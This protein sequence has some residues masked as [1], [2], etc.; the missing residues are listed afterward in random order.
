MDLEE[1]DDYFSTL[2]PENTLENINNLIYK[3]HDFSK[4]SKNE[5]ITEPL[6]NDSTDSENEEDTL[7]ISD[8]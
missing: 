4:Y 1:T 2:E 7:K 6:F 5:E 8:I 3:S